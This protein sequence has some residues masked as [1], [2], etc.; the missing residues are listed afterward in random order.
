MIPGGIYEAHKIALKHVYG[1][2]RGG[3]AATGSVDAEEETT[4][5]GFGFSV[6]TRAV[7]LLTPHSGKASRAAMTTCW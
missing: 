4:P 6:P 1:V 7:E 2:N 3:A 5:T